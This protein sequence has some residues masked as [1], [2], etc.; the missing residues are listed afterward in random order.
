VRFPSVVA[1]V[2]LSLGILVGLVIRGHHFAFTVRV[3][4][5]Q[6]VY[7]SPTIPPWRDPAALLA[8]F[9]GATIAVSICS[10]APSLAP[11]ECRERP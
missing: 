10:D 11:R 8:G 5:L 9:F 6:R 3:N 2:L 7:Q 4:R 1:A